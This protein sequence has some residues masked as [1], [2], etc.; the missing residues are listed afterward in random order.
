I[1]TGRRDVACQIEEHLLGGAQVPTLLLHGPRRMG[2]SSLLNQL[3]RLLGP[4]FAPALV[5]CQA[6]AVSESTATMLR[7]LSESVSQ[8]PHRLRIPVAPLTSADLASEPF[9]RFMDWVEDVE[10][11]LSLEMRVLI[12]L[13]EYESLQRALD[14]GWGSLLFDTLRHVIQHQPHL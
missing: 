6:P 13:D 11:R 8:S 4:R 9:T 2:K 14:D 12:C 7:Y 3:P 10:S 5:D 1:F